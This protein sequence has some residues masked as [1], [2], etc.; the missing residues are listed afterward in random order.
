[1]R[2]RSLTEVV[3]HL[4]ASGK[5]GIISGTEIRVRQSAVG[6]T[7]RDRFISWKDKRN[8]IK[9]IVDTVGEDRVL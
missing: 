6:R 8:A 3:N 1:M 4:G 7:D 9:T 5:T 2:L